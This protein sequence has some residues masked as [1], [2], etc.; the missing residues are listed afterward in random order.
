MVAGI[1][2]LLHLMANVNCAVVMV[3][4]TLQKEDFLGAKEIKFQ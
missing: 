2:A 4:I 1:Y 3:V